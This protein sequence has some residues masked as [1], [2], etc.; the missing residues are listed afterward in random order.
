MLSKYL[1]LP[2]INPQAMQQPEHISYSFAH[3]A[4]CRQAA[5]NTPGLK[6]SHNTAPNFAAPQA[7]NTLPLPGAA[8]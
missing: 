5:S 3:H 8:K 7:N 2:T 4:N 6:N 1:Y